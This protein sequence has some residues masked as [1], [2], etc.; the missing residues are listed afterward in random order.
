M[1]S[2]PVTRWMDLVSSILFSESSLPRRL[3][4]AL[5]CCHRVLGI[6]G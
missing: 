4:R 6:W 2:R 5:L 3:S 1:P